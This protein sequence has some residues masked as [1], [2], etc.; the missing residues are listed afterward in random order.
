MQTM[1]QGERQLTRLD[2]SRLRKLMAAGHLAD[3]AE[4]LDEADV[5]DPREIP[6]DAVTMYAQF[7]IRDLKT[8]QRRTLVLC[9]PVD[10]EPAQGYVS[11]L[12]PVGMSLLGQRVG[13]TTRWCTPDGE[14]HF[15]QV[16]SILFQPEATGDYVT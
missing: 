2:V 12:S 1:P 9:Y 10:A 8:Q 13:T 7:V 15:A 11:V 16:E 5:V 4:L 14:E 6:A 3:L